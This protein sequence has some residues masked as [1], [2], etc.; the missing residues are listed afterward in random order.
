MQLRNIAIAGVFVLLVATPVA[1]AKP[2][3]PGEPSCPA[4]IEAE[5]SAIDAGWMCISAAEIQP[6]YVG[7]TL[8]KWRW[9]YSA[10]MYYGTTQR[11]TIGSVRQTAE[12]TINGRQINSKQGQGTFSG[13]AIKSVLTSRCID[14]NGL[15][16]DGGCGESVLRDTIYRTATM[17]NVGQTYLSQDERYWYQFWYKWWA[18]GATNPSSGDGA[19]SAFDNPK[20]SDDFICSSSYPATEVCRFY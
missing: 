12:I 6:L 11:G 19:F 10:T 2:P 16:P 3:P 9:T 14:D 4:R 17:T 20:I 13:P 1:A 18:S 15:L 7:T 5:G 8:S